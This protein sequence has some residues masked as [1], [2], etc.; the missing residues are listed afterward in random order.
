MAPI[1]TKQPTML[2]L[3]GPNGAGKSTFYNTFLAE[4]PF[5]KDFTFIN[6]DIIA[7]ELS[8][9]EED[10][11]NY[12]IEA[13][14]IASNHLKDHFYNG[15]SFIYEST[16]AGRTPLKLL[17][18]TKE[19][20]YNT[21]VIFVGL[22]N[23]KLSLLRVLQRVRGGGHNIPPEDIERRYPRILKNLPDL[24]VESD[25]SIIFDNSEKQP[26]QPII[27]VDD[28]TITYFNKYPKWLRTDLVE[29]DKFQE[30]IAL[31]NTY[32]IKSSSNTIK[33][34]LSKIQRNQR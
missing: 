14:K 3:L 18:L 23:P 7:K 27:M 20:N 29:N 12:L 11:N 13:G 15:Q 26:Y 31:K 2:L 5:F 32:N 25:I 33:Q 34:F 1:A 22:S 17:R 28:N 16:A 24:I 8:N 19:H 9:S 6:P 10:P 30:H 4:D 21:A